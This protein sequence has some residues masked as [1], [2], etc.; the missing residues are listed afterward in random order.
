[1]YNNLVENCFDKCVMTAWGG[2]SAV[3]T[4][5]QLLCYHNLALP[6]H[7][8]VLAQRIFQ[9]KKANASITAQKNS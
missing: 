8:R 7:S 4:F 6:L 2:V 9:N 5:D 3:D 1:M